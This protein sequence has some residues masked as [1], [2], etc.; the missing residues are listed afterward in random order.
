MHYTFLQ[1][2]LDRMIRDGGIPEDIYRR[3]SFTDHLLI[4]SETK[5]YK[6]FSAF[7]ESLVDDVVP[8]RGSST[9]EQYRTLGE[10]LLLNLSKSSFYGNWLC[11][12]GDSK[13]FN[14]SK[15][16][17]YKS[18]KVFDRWRK[19][20]ESSGLITS[21]Q[22]KA[23]E[24]ARMTN[25][26]YPTPEF[27]RQLSEFSLYL[28]SPIRPPYLRI[29]EPDPAFNSFQWPEGHEERVFL[30][31]FNEFAK[32]HHWAHKSPIVQVFK[33]NP[34]QAGRLITNFQSLRSR[35]YKIRINTLI[36]GNP[37]A[38]VDFNANHLRLFLAFNECPY[39]GDDPYIEIAEAT[40]RTRAEVKG[41]INIALNC[42]SLEQA[43]AAA[44][45]EWHVPKSASKKIDQFLK[46]E[47]PKLNFYEGFGLTAQ[48]MEGLILSRVMN[49]G[50][51]RGILCLPIH[52][53]IA[54]EEQNAEWAKSAMEEAWSDEVN[55]MWSSPNNWNK[56]LKTAVGIERASDLN[57]V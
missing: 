30:E 12:Y 5:P 53:A 3:H 38:E 11:I 4:D 10:Q 32:G 23:Y 19:Y 44:L 47:Y 57:K 29:N 24:K 18:F 55:L 50:M 1:S 7:L 54:V 35:N 40:G 46:K 48:Q 28:E 8:N 39:S 22:G 43:E 25:R 37:I 34:F 33:H 51:D 20:L 26:F 49:E 27:H 14:K 21:L 52:D 16:G 45:S 17:V 42:N 36:N 31:D 15:D 56:N 13:E 6:A 9:R 2:E 41:F